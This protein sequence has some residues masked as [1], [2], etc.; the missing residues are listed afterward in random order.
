MPAGRVMNA[1]AT[2]CASR[3]SN[4]SRP[5]HFPS[6]TRVNAASTS[7]SAAFR[8]ARMPATS[9]SPRHLLVCC[10]RF[11]SSGSTSSP[12]ATSAEDAFAASSGGCRSSPAIVSSRLSRRTSLV[13]AGAAALAAGGSQATATPSSSFVARVRSASI[14][15]RRA[16]SRAS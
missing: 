10:S 9:A 11:R 13:T 8:L 5:S 16:W 1:A 6:T 12:A 3:R 7:A 14:G 15:S 4:G 2:P